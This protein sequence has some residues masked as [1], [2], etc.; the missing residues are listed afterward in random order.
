MANK[1][2]IIGRFF[3]I[4]CLAFAGLAA[5]WGLLIGT[6]EQVYAASPQPME[7]DP[8]E[9]FA[10]AFDLPRQPSSNPPMVPLRNGSG[11]SV[12]TVCKP[13]GCDF[14]SVQAAV[15]SVAI[16]GIVKVA[17]GVYTDTDGQD[18]VVEITKTLTLRGGY[19]TADWSISN[20]VLYPT[21]LDG[22][23]SVRVINIAGEADPTVEGF[24]IFDGSAVDGGGV[25]IA[26]GEPTLRRNRIYSSTATGDGAGVY[27]ASGNPILEN[28]LIYTN[29][30]AANG[31]GVY[32]AAGDSFLRHN[33]LYGNQA[34]TRGGG[35]YIAA[36]APIISAT[37]IVN[38][39]AS[40]GAGGVHNAGGAPF[41]TYNDVWG[42]SNPQYSGVT[43]I[44][45]SISQNPLFKNVS[46]ADFRLQATSPCVDWI[47]MHTVEVDYRGWA[48]PFGENPD[49]GAYEFYTGTCFA[50]VGAGRIYTTVQAAVDVASVDD[51]VK[52][53]GL[54]AGVEQRSG[55][56]QT[57]Y[58]DQALT[59]RGGYTL[60]NWSETDP[61]VYPTILD[62]QGMGR[63]GYIYSVEAVQIEGFHIRN[64]VITGTGNHGSGLYL[65]GGDHV[66]LENRIYD[67]E[68][69][70]KGGGVYIAGGNPTLRSN[71]VYSNDAAYG[72]GLGI[73]NS[74]SILQSNWVYSNT[75]T[76]GGGI[77]F[78][79]GDSD[80]QSNWIYTNTAEEKGGG[81]YVENSGIDIEGNWIYDNRVNAS[82]TD[83]GGG[84]IYIGSGTAPTVWGNAIYSNVIKSGSSGGGINMYEPTGVVVEQNTIHHNG[85]GFRGGGIY[86]RSNNPTIQNNLIYG[87]TAT[88]YGGGV[89][90]GNAAGVI[91]GNVIYDNSAGTNGAGI[92]K[93]DGGSSPAIRNNVV[94]SN[95]GDG[96][97][98][99]LGGT[100]EIYYSNVWNNTGERCGGSASCISA[101]GNITA[102]PQFVDPG[103]NFA[104]EPGSPC[105]DA[106][107]PDDYPAEDYDGRAR[108][109]GSAPDMGAYEYYVG[110]CFAQVAGAT[111][112]YTTVQAAIDVVTQ[113]TTVRVAGICEGAQLRTVG[114]ETFT[115]TAYVSQSLTLRGGYTVAVGLDD[116]VWVTPTTQTI[117]D[118]LGD[119]RAIYITGTG[120]VTVDGFILR[121]GD[122]IT[123]AGLYV[124]APLSSTVQNI[125]FYSNTAQYGG[126]LASVGGDSHLYNNTFVTNTA[127]VT[128]GGLYLADGSPTISNTIVVSNAG[129][130][131][132]T[133]AGVT[134]SLA[135][136]DVMGNTGGD[137]VGSASAGGTDFSAGPLFEDFAGY[138]FHLAVGSPC[139]HTAD[140]DTNL[141]CDLEGDVRPLGRGSDVG[142]DEAALY[143]DVSFAPYSF[144]DGIPGE[145]TIH[146]HFLTNTGS[147]TD[148]FDLTYTLSVSE[149][150]WSVSYDP[151]SEFV[152]GEVVEFPVSLL[153]PGDAVSGTE[154]TVV[155]TAS[156][157]IDHAIYD[158]VS[159]TTLVNWNPGVAFTPV[160]TQY[161]N[162][163]AVLTYVHTLTNTGNAVD[164]FQLG[165]NSP[166]GWSGVTPTLISD[167][168]SYM[169][170][171]VWVTVAV[172]STA[173]GDIHET[174][175]VSAASLTSDAGATVTDMTIV[176]HPPG[177]RYVAQTGEADDTLNNCQ[178]ADEPCRHI[179][180]AVEQAVGG[181]VIKVAKG[182]YSE[183]DIKI[184]KN[185]TL[186]GGHDEND[187]EFAPEVNQ[188]T[189]NAQGMGRVFYIFGSPI[190]EGFT[191]KGGSTAG[192]G[193]GI[194]VSQG[195]PTIRRNRITGNSAGKGGGFAT[196]SGD[197][198]FWNNLIYGNTASENGGGVYVADGNP[199]IWHDTI[200][201]NTANRGGGIYLFSG[202]PTVE[203]NIIVEN[204]A[205]ITGSG[206]YSDTAGAALAYNNVWHNDY[207][208]LSEVYTSVNPS[209]VAAGASNFHLRSSSPCRDSGGGSSLTEDF[210]GQPR[211]M[212]PQPDIGAYEF[213][214]YGV[215]IS[216][217]W[218]DRG[219]PGE[220]VEYT[221]IVQNTGNYTDTFEVWGVSDQGWTVT[222]L[223]TTPLEMTLGAGQTDTMKVLVTING[224]AISGTVDATTVTAESQDSPYSDEDTT[225]DHTTVKRIWGMS[226]T[227]QPGWHTR[228]NSDPSDPVYATFFHFIENNGNY[229]DTYNLGWDSSED[230]AV[231][232]QPDPIDVGPNLSKVIWVTVTVPAKPSDEKVIDRTVITATS[233]GNGDQDD[234]YDETVVNYAIGLELGPNQTS[235][236]D[237]GDEIEHSYVLTNTG[238]YWDVFSIS[239]FG[240]GSVDPSGIDVVQVAAGGTTTITLSG[241]IPDDALCDDSYTTII[242]ATSKWNWLPGKTED[243][244]QDVVEIRRKNGLDLEP[245]LTH[246]V[247]SSDSSEV[248]VL[249]SH[250]LT[251]TGNCE[252]T[253]YFDE[254]SS[255]LGFTTT[256]SPG[257]AASVTLSPGAKT[258]V[259]VTV[260]VP[261]TETLCTNRLVDITSISF[262]DESGTLSDVVTETTIVNQCVDL[263]LVPDRTTVITS[264]SISAVQVGYTHTLINTGN[265]T[266]TFDLFGISDHGWTV[267]PD[268]ADPLRIT[269]GQDCSTTVAVSVTVGPDIVTATEQT[270]FTATSNVPSDGAVTY[271]PTA[272]VVNTTMVR[273]PDLT[274]IPDF[275]YNVFP[276][277][278]ITYA[279]TL[280]NTGGVT[281]TYFLTYVN[282]LEGWAVVTPATIYNLA[283]GQAA[284]VTV[285]VHVPTGTDIL[286]GTQNMLL[287]TATSQ[288]T[289]V[290]P[291]Y[292]TAVDTITVPY[293]PGAEIVWSETGHTMPGGV[294]T[295]THILTNTGNYTEAFDLTTHSDFGFSDFEDPAPPPGG[296]PSV[297]LGPWEAYTHVVVTVL[298]PDHAAAGETELTEVGVSIA[299]E[300][301]L[302]AV[303]ND[304][305]IV[306]PTTGVRYVARGGTDVNNNCRIPG[307][308]GPCATIQQ[309]VDQAGMWSN[310]QIRV[311]Q[312]VY[313]DILATGGF[314]RVVYLDKDVELLGGYTTDDWNMSAPS[315]YSTTLDAGGQGR[316]IYVE[317]GIN[318]TIDGFYLQ[319]G[320]VSG[321][322]G[323][324]LYIETGA[325][326]TVRRNV[327][328]NNIAAGS[329]S[330]GGGLYHGGAGN[331][332]LEQNT[333][334][335]NVAASGGGVYL[336]G[337]SGG[338]QDILNNV[339]YRNTSSEG[340]KGG[341]L[342]LYGGTARVW[343]DTFYNNT[344]GSN[345]GGGIYI[346]SGGS[347]V[348]S[349]TIVANHS[350][351]Y[352]IYNSDG[353]PSLNYSL[354]WDNSPDDFYG[355]TLGSGIITD[356]PPGFVNAAGG[357]FHLRSNSLALDVADPNTTLTEDRDGN[358]RPLPVSGGYDIGAYENGLRIG[359]RAVE[360]GT[361]GEIIT[362]TIV[363][364]NSGTVKQDIGITDTLHHH[365]DYIGVTSNAAGSGNYSD[366]IL[367]WEGEV[368]SSTTA[369]ITVTAT[370]TDWLVA[371]TSITNMAWINSV[372]SSIVT[373]VVTGT[374]GARYVAQTDVATNALNNCLQPDLPCRTIQY[375]VDRALTGD[376]VRAASGIYTG[377]GQVVYAGKDL[378]LK[379]GYT[380]T[381][382][383]WTY[384]PSAY[385]TTLNAQT[386][387]GVVVT[388]SATVMLGGLRIVNGA[389]GVD[390]NA[391]TVVISQCYIYSNT[392]GV[393][394]SDG[395]YTLINNV[396]AHNSG[397]G[398][399]TDGS[400][401]SLLHNT[402]ARNTGAGV[403]I[404]DTAHFTNTIFYSH[405]VGLDVATGGSA[406]LSNTLWYSNTVNQGAIISST[407]L[408]DQDPRF[409]NPDGMDYHIQ[410]GSSVIDQGLDN[411]LSEDIDG[412]H[413]P[414][415]ALPDLGADELGLEIAKSVSH[416]DADPGQTI[417]YSI[418]LQGGESVVLTDTL[419]TYLTYITGTVTCPAGGSCGYLSAQRAITWTGSVPIDS[420]VYI[421]YTA[422]ITDWLA[423]G[424]EIP[425]QAE[426]LIAGDILNTTEVKTTIEDVSGARYVDT[427][428]GVDI[429]GAGNNCLASWKPC[430]TV[431][432]AVDQVWDGDTVKTAAGIYTTG[433]A[434]VVTVSNSIT[435]TG[436]YTTTDD[437]NASDPDTNLTRL[438]AQGNGR[439]M[440]ITGPVTVKVNG[441]HLRNGAVTGNSVCGAGLYVYSSTVTLADSLVYNNVISGA[442]SQGGGVC[443]ISGALTI[444][445]THIYSNASDASTGGG[446]YY[447]GGDFSLVNSQVYSNT[448]GTF[449][450]GLYLTDADA[451]LIDNRIYTNTASTGGGLR[452]FD[453]DN[454]HME[455]N[456]LLDNQANASGGGIS[457]WSTAHITMTNNVIGSNRAS[458]GGDGLSF[459]GSGNGILLHNTV[460]D[461]NDGNDS[462]GLRVSGF[463]LGLTNTILSGHSVAITTSSASA[464][465][466]ADHTLW[467]G[468]GIY[469]DTDGTITTTNDLVGSPNYYG[470]AMMD[471]HITGSSAAAGAGIDVGVE[472]DIDGESRFSPPDVGADQY[473]LRTDRWASSAEGAPCEMV[474]HT[475]A[476]TNVADSV[477]SGVALTDTLPISV[478]NIDSITSTAGSAGYLGS[479]HAITWAGDVAAQSS[480][481]IT[482]TV[483][484]TPYLADGAVLSFTATISDPSSIFS[485]NSLP[486]TVRTITATIRKDGWGGVAPAGE[487]IIGELIT[488]TVVYT[489]PGG[490][491]AYE[492]VVVDVLPQLAATPAMTYVMD[493]ASI[494]GSSIQTETISAD[495]GTITWTLDTMTAACSA[496]ETATLTFNARLLDRVGTAG[497]KL[498]NNAALT[499]T[500][501]SASG[502]TRRIDD[503][504]A[505][506]LIEPEL[507]LTHNASVTQNLGVNDLVIITVTVGNVGNSTLHDVLATDTLQGAWVVS[508]TS[509]AKV[510]THSFESIDADD[511]KLITFTAR[512]GETAGA[513]ESLVADVEALGTSLSGD[514]PHE[515]V[516]TDTAQTA[517]T[518]G[519]PDLQIS[520]SGL[521]ECASGQRFSYTIAYTNT[522]KV[523]A[524]GVQITDTWPVSLTNI[525][526][527]TS[528]GATATGASQT[529]T[530][531]LTDP[532]SPTVSG[533]VW[534]T[535]TVISGIQEGDV[536]TNLAG[537]TATATAEDITVDNNDF[538]TSTVVEPQA[539]IT[540][541]MTPATSLGAGDSVTVTLTIS[542]TGTGTLYDVVVTDT[543]PAGLNFQSATM[544]YGQ[545]GSVVTWTLGSLAEE[546][547]Q[548]YTIT[549][550]VSDTMGANET[551]SNQAD[552]WGASWSGEVSERHT[553]TDTAQ[554]VATTGYPDLQIS[555]SGPDV[556]SP[557]QDIAY[558]IAY[559]NA[560]V[561]QAVDVRVT[562]T[563]LFL[564][565][566]VLSDT[567]PTASQVERVNQTITWT[568]GAVG[569]GDNGRIWITTT[570]PL[571]TSKGAVMT[572]T[573][574]ITTTTV[575][576]N[577]T[578]NDDW[579]TTTVQPPSLNI[580]K[581]V[582]PLQP[583]T[584][585]SLTY[586][587]T[588]SNAGPG[589]ATDVLISDSVPL[590]TTYQGCN[591]GDGCGFDSGSN[592]VTWTLDLLRTGQES[593][594]FTVLVD[595]DAY[596][597]TAIVNQTYGVTCTQGVTDTADTPLTSTVPLSRVLLLEPASAQKSVLPDG[598]L[599][600]THTL[601]NWGTVMATVNLTVSDASPGWQY[602][603]EPVQITDLGI[604]ADAEKII[605][606]TVHA[607]ISDAQAAAVITA[608]WQGAPSIYDMA[609]DTTTVDLVQNLSLT[610]P[611]ESRNIMPGEQTFY[612]H[613]LTNLGNLTAT[614][615]L[616]V[617]LAPSDWT[618]N[619]QPE[620]VG[621][622]VDLASSDSTVITLTVGSGAGATG[623]TEATITATWQSAPSVYDTARDTTIIDCVPVSGVS[624]NYIPSGPVLGQKI[625][626]S[627]T[628]SEGTPPFSW[629]WD[630]DDGSVDTGQFVTHAYDNDGSYGVQLTV[631][632]C[633]GAFSDSDTRTVIVSPYNI[634]LPLVLRNY[635]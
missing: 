534:V 302:L 352:G 176:N 506:V 518:T 463:T 406:Y 178:V 577:E 114:S 255:S 181:D 55:Y 239:A 60:T 422:Q 366:R 360:F 595:S 489:V 386:S 117:L 491:K 225:V 262:T 456:W 467:D 368:Y 584:A 109:F 84:G 522:G 259:H 172:P 217:G 305:T 384:D 337:I 11:P 170:A 74:D 124:A 7:S 509:D 623:S 628:L 94:V 180:Y 543:L 231:T 267:D 27:I 250:L 283:P 434:T 224:N 85:G 266:D 361:A 182:A 195:G 154:A 146:T 428:T 47:P 230:W 274:L 520:K 308:Y 203:N 233:Q 610:P 160:Y 307:E 426:A 448:A 387:A 271:T 333:V 514:E 216:S 33:T 153:V 54:C 51:V 292:D 562:D 555:K 347:P 458:T 412:D 48:R 389:D 519:Y 81:V 218:S 381:L 184:N 38:N 86:I 510:I 403:V 192:S 625:A 179:T 444:T 327:I 631:T 18:G 298:L 316:V 321:G 490:H 46:V 507:A 4:L 619:L 445:A 516:Y 21:I 465:V 294:F 531:T 524:E 168:G 188:T 532:V 367:S 351:G 597:G 236:D 171:T 348:I 66:I 299:D 300:R 617:S 372:P 232:V 90:L 286:S 120:A 487:A 455:R 183:H 392:D 477:I 185:I 63:V 118:A 97:Y 407:S 199:R 110:D 57:V 588:I 104:L 37:V 615:D 138:D 561:V 297:E 383:T 215:Q 429:D 431:Q 318:A 424:T 148:T 93:G 29:T 533:A 53:A 73:V 112:V 627:G 358:Q 528:A 632:N 319:G 246:N 39:A 526:S 613:T 420:P 430:A 530:W 152:P 80:I 44:E 144:G 600:Y 504:A 244:A 23:G 91:D 281:S 191:V 25:Y 277:N 19:T 306:S 536:L 252:D 61:D 310:D 43:S 385:T 264:P 83:L 131:V 142:A 551:L 353:A 151:V 369:Y 492:P 466:V 630:F 573:A 488:Y 256:V 32:I 9:R 559:T 415:L 612:T 538:V 201:N 601:T 374:P 263:D 279:H 82:Q 240:W 24:R 449:G 622:V 363:V 546:Q 317:G 614:F 572:N 442:G 468:S 578:N 165:L 140:P 3:L 119:G 280:S 599:V 272:A 204:S 481:H 382:P 275:S 35:I 169:T 560:G 28:N 567:S 164:S 484:I 574:A 451:V 568:L 17:Q 242:T 378:T 566:D 512:V 70:E 208:G 106:G 400:I 634:Y 454:V 193:G 98:N 339:I 87:N 541:T 336:D 226:L 71:D 464:S 276:G 457:A 261:A 296:N 314:T 320:Y 498:T 128:G 342:Y 150:G 376:E 111:R 123:G 50:R 480:V 340:E 417:T 592:L 427:A 125:I 288:F 72:G 228:I 167:L 341:G 409:E 346:D 42:N 211:P 564:L 177:D 433:A 606:L 58:I 469:T 450:G 258:D 502:P 365:L 229:T 223:D 575:E 220:T 329:G 173:P 295:Y 200:Y 248:S 421:T 493:S 249:Y 209:F 435:L 604:G 202:S 452:I 547:Q 36:G 332:L 589:D 163:G 497:D 206:V 576:L 554:A 243:T 278:N 590:S 101:N 470:R 405:S 62:A 219:V 425:N 598:R 354:V 59:L 499:Y 88:D 312:G 553:Y 103:V 571:T 5:V 313:T 391:A 45:E 285:T 26:D 289:D 356:T 162:P 436:G 324:G 505:L 398:V 521:A 410:A 544:P 311:A 375:A 338:I 251:N 474:T 594:A 345:G 596:S 539:A 257:S 30:G 254:A 503:D 235:Y 113:P 10:P 49:I 344:A 158:V 137:Y 359:K 214:E 373:T 446:I 476:L 64:G 328:Y 268:S 432:R 500:E 548:I 570:V 227:P 22:A 147:I 75:A 156:S 388:N 395:S 609:I 284:P 122:A 116:G 453:S 396:V 485:G 166:Y 95:T 581:S 135:Y 205:T 399:Q 423:A 130:G 473:N 207:V 523:R 79:G 99:D 69:D 563:L 213:R 616:D 390:V 550:L 241:T 483:N 303:V 326:P 565:T 349:N 175:V 270:I 402:F 102:S 624:I 127:T 511:S 133:G 301:G 371:G 315:E 411:W 13:S 34:I 14:T 513:V 309:A 76:N 245:S 115:Q 186:R 157:T 126:G 141:A 517:A 41:L 323:A 273:R 585:R 621:A 350:A 441:F 404:S 15:D 413:R 626:F 495:G 439:A 482:Y 105:I 416:L 8:A 460:A 198:N 357:D 187:W 136:N 132:W 438:D 2:M 437:W 253:F 121:G 96:I 161:V 475:L 608:T 620:G 556:R 471:Y 145:P 529:I 586:T 580:T 419:H 322:P 501:G 31:G 139:I 269:L 189:V 331:I 155:F 508:G 78:S 515:R 462:E 100:H 494:T 552:V 618:Y 633:G 602:D 12:V 414:L 535:G 20:P 134:L 635:N 287:I 6:R 397:A 364:T 1:K 68:S 549:T 370:I 443:A 108:P 418:K 304:S 557:G 334:Y 325:A 221:H 486:V 237:P 558:T 343:N 282:T 92:Y 605:T 440:V 525:V 174:A 190:V 393:D 210:D 89:S 459:T 56:T 212:G 583:L 569:R 447:S 65:N 143:A 260:T 52:V 545:V 408:F 479:S 537:I 335:S 291:I 607:P 593:V 582:D 16:G 77:Y 247:V 107:D 293:D 380:P 542:N 478:T 238:E 579:I 290:M 67:N 265:Y 629:D 587:L 496:P 472:A 591:G 129:G 540:K 149:A 222:P 611:T 401:G 234:I 379:G 603:L 194:Y 355:V 196:L 40:I 377:T 159:N 362:Y 197:A 461:N 330:Q 394:V 527:A